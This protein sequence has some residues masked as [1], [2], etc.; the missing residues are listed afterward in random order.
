MVRAD[1][2]Q[3]REKKKRGNAGREPADKGF[4]RDHSV[5]DKSGEHA[6]DQIEKCEWFADRGPDRQLVSCE[7]EPREKGSGDDGLGGEPRHE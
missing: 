6:L 7:K 4:R 5:R 1:R 2:E 3:T